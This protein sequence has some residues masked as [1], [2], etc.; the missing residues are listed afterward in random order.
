MAD[1][2]PIKRAEELVPSKEK[3]QKALADN[4][5]EGVQLRRLAKVR[6]DLDDLAAGKT[7]EKKRRKNGEE[8]PADEAA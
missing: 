1:V 8:K 4:A 6:Q 5:K 7:P 2:E 3:I